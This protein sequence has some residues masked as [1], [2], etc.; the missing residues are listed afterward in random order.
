[1]CFLCEPLCVEGKLL[2]QIT[3]LMNE[4]ERYQT[5]RMEKTNVGNRKKPCKTVYSDIFPTAFYGFLRF[6]T[7]SYGYLR[8]STI[9]KIL[10]I[11][12]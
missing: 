8:F 5:T 11:G 1:M 2:V 6:S 9:H 10:R 7:V 4:S 12:T 3:K